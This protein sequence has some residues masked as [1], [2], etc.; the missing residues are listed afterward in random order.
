M[1][2]KEN[3]LDKSYVDRI[4]LI[5]VGISYIITTSWTFREEHSFKN[6]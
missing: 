4:M 3:K 2:P 5:Y 1:R 6:P